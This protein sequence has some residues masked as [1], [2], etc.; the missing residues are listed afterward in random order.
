MFFIISE[1]GSISEASS[2]Q[3]RIPRAVF[4]LGDGLELTGGARRIK[5]YTNE[6]PCKELL[7]YSDLASNFSRARF[8]S[9]TYRLHQITA[10][11]L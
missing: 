3:N 1:F 9:R 10:F 11:L 7:S 2:G 8:I 4:M 5:L 6:Q